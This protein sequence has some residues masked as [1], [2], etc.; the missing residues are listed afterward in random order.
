MKAKKGF[1]FALGLTFLGFIVL[2][3]SVFIFHNSQE[4]EEIMSQLAVLDRVYDLDVSIQEALGYTI[5]LESGIMVNITEEGVSFEE[6]LPNN[7]RQGFNSSIKGFKGFIESNL[8][9]IGLTI[10]NIDELPLK[11]MPNDINYKHRDD[12]SSIEVIPDSINFDG[13]SLQIT[14]DKN[15]SCIWDVNSGSFNLSLEVIGDS[16]SCSKQTETIDPSVDN[17]VRVESIGEGDIIVIRV[18]NDGIL[19]VNLTQDVSIRAKTTVLMDG[20]GAAIGADEIIL[21]FDFV[22]FGVYKATGVRVR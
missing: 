16:S 2:T 18:T 14:T 17:E 1:L 21:S 8:S 4:Y 3:L 19:L 15:V 10:T 5:G 20:S 7:N 13:Y 9:N 11:I 22:D 12:W 6:D